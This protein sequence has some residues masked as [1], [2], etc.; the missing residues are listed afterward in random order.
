MDSALTQ[1]IFFIV[2]ACDCFDDIALHCTNITSVFDL[3][4][5]LATLFQPADFKNSKYKRSL[6][7]FDDTQLNFFYPKL[8][9]FLLINSM[10]YLGL[11]YCF[12]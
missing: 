1:Q 7:I 5:S 4:E 8:T 12:T 2:N 3:L 11:F 9:F 6:L 10:V